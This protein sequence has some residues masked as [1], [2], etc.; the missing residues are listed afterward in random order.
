MTKA[1]SPNSAKHIIAIAAMDESRAIGFEN[2]LPWN[3]PEDLKR[4][5]ELTKGHAVLMGRKTWESLPERVRPLPG[6]L[7]I[8]CSRRPGSLSTPQ[9]VLTYSSAS[10]AIE[11]FLSSKIEAPTDKLYVIGGEQIYKE[12]L[13]FWTQLYLTCVHSKHNGDAFFPDF[14]HLFTLVQNDD[15]KGFSFRQYSRTRS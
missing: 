1:L 13:P 15:R 4:F 12:T 14:E 11:D 3:I 2:K 9:G 8:V 7:N 6:R 10:G 5:S